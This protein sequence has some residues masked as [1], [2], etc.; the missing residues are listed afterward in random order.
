MATASAA[1][2]AASATP[3]AAAATFIVTRSRA[4]QVWAFGAACIVFALAL[5]LWRTQR[6]AAR[7]RPL[8]HV[9]VVHEV[10][11]LA[12]RLRIR[13]AVTV[14]QADGDAMPMTWGAW[15]PRILVPASFVGWPTARRQAVLLHELA[16]V[17]RWDWLTQLV[18]RLACALY[19]WN[20]L[21]WVAARRLREER[22]LACDDLV[23]AHGTVASAYAGD[24][25]EI[26]RAYRAGPATALTGVAMA[27][28]SQLADRLLAVLDAAR[29]R[30]TLA[31]RHAVS[32][33]GA[34]L[35][36]MLPVA[37]LARGSA[38]LTPDPHPSTATSPTTAA[39]APAAA[40]AV[41]WSAPRRVAPPQAGRALLCDWAAPS[42]S[43]SSSTSIDDDR[44]TIRIS[45]DDDCSITVRADGEVTF[46]DD[47]RDITR[48]ARQGFFEVEERTPRARRRVEVAERDGGLERHWFVEGR[49]QPYDDAA[50]AWLADVLLVL[51]RRA[52][53]NAEARATR[54]FESQGEDGL[55]AEIATLQSDHVAGRYYRVLFERG[56]LSS[57]QLSRLLA[58]AARRIESD[59]ELGRVLATVAARGPMDDTVQRAY[60][61]AAESLDSD[62]EHARALLSL[63]EGATIDPAALDAMLAS[64]RR[65]DSDHE[66]SRL[67]LAVADRY[68]TE[69]PLPAS[70]LEAVGDMESDH[71]RGRVL[72]RLLTRDQL[73]AADRARVLG[74]VRRIGSDHTQGQIL[75]AVAAAGP[76][77]EV[78]R[79]AFFAAVE[80]IE[81]DHT[82]QEVLRAV[83]SAGPEETTTLGVLEAARRI[84]S[85]HSKGEVLLAVAQ[86]G[87]LSERVRAAY[88]SVARSIG[89]R[90]TQD[91]V[92]RAAGLLG[93]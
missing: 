69:R 7:S 55:I 24:L 70:Y 63:T 47:D 3:P 68:P 72:Q 27:R 13:R 67:L 62:H 51:M 90:H 58:D 44:M 45:R 93:G 11:E 76:L 74:V 2:P 83:I 91:R 88:L 43:N 59:H 77:D 54:I 57:A 60:V 36:V 39:P 78:T 17:K 81:S 21:A 66:R 4:T 31:P 10:A 40:P 64:S 5:S 75:E 80:G 92:L 49:E 46:S 86:R 87:A 34:A 15:R 41:A 89:S 29:S 16:H 1:T 53:I 65:I 82:R 38:E 6:L 19:W 9:G 35:I 42:E 20:P 33:A 85:D 25:L 26:A 37:G 50:R 73:S 32:A 12:R 28:R 84:A 30:G 56:R 48:V 52:G 61:Q 18:A 71:E 79:E 8:A 22:E 14:L 23:L